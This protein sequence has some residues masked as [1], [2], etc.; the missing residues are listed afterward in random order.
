[1]GLKMT[2]QNTTVPDPSWD[3]SYVWELMHDAMELIVDAKKLIG[4]CENS[5]RQ[6]NERVFRKFVEASIKLSDCGRHVSERNRDE[7]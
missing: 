5:N 4:E 7:Q 2:N 3:Y 1:M 6:V